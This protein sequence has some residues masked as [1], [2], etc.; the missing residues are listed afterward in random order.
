MTMSTPS[1]LLAYLLHSHPVLGLLPAIQPTC[2]LHLL[3]TSGPSRSLLSALC[4]LSTHT[5]LS[6]V[7]IGLPIFATPFC[8][9]V[10]GLAPALIL[11]L[12][13]RLTF[14]P[15]IP[16]HIFSTLLAHTQ[17]LAHTRPLMFCLPILPRLRRLGNFW[18][19]LETCRPLLLQLEIH[20]LILHA[21]FLMKLK[22]KLKIKP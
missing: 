18:L 4:R 3:G 19:S 9:R 12:S 5:T 14:L 10:S 15:A 8:T 22:L 7:S 20:L 21:P 13:S 16:P 2:S 1:L 11:G 6:S 17:S